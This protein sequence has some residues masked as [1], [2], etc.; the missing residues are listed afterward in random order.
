MRTTLKSGDAPKRGRLRRIHEL[1]E[2]DPIGP[3]FILLHSSNSLMGVATGAMR[4]S[5]DTRRAT[6]AIS[7]STHSGGIGPP[8]E[9]AKG[10]RPTPLDLRDPAEMP[11]IPLDLTVGSAE[12]RAKPRLP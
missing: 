12:R 2:A 4:P 8:A 5:W 1:A 10:Q 6:A 11:R 7:I 3:L 9:S